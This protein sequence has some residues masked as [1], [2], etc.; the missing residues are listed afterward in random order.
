MPDSSAA[1]PFFVFA[2]PEY[3]PSG[4]AGDCAGIF[5]T[6]QEA[7]DCL[8][9]ETGIDWGTVEIVRDYQF[10]TVYDWIDGMVSD[11]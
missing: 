9:G 2:G 8:K 1:G 4:G 3:Y 5:P 10:V 7:I 11:G 6:L